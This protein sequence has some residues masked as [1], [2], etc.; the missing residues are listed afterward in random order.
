MENASANKSGL[1]TSKV[2]HLIVHSN[3]VSKNQTENGLNSLLITTPSAQTSQVLSRISM[4]NYL[5]K[6]HSINCGPQRQ[7]DISHAVVEKMSSH[8]KSITMETLS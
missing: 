4:V 6:L 3:A 7:K 1:N 5:Q 8:G 2:C